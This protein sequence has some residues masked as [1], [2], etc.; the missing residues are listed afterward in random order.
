MRRTYESS[1]FPYP[2]GTLLACDTSSIPRLKRS[3]VLQRWYSRV[4]SFQAFRAGSSEA[5]IRPFFSLSFYG[6]VIC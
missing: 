4:S 2:S 1:R 3:N 6:C 5:E